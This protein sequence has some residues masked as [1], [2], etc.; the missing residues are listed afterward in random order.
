[1]RCPTSSATGRQ[2]AAFLPASPRSSPVDIINLLV[3]QA[4]QADTTRLQAPQGSEFADFGLLMRQV[5]TGFNS[6]L[7]AGIPA[8][9]AALDAGNLRPLDAAELGGREGNSLPE[10]AEALRDNLR[11]GGLAQVPENASPVLVEDQEEA[12]QAAATDSSNAPVTSPL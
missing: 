8:A 12:E 4:G 9:E 3:N 6:A 2:L 1:R 11:R 5:A 7:P 10:L